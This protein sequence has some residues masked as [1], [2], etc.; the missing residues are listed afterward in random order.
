M[1][2]VRQREA[3]DASSRLACPESGGSSE[4][5]DASDARRVRLC[6]I[7]LAVLAAA[8]LVQIFSPLR[9][10]PDAVIY[11]SMARSAADGEG[12]YPQGRRTHFPPGYPAML[13][14]LDRAGL[15]VSWAFV[16]LN[17]V[18]LAVGLA[19]SYAVLR[20][21]FAFERFSALLLCCLVLLSYQ[22]FKHVA[23]PLSDV[24]FFAVSMLCVLAAVKAEGRADAG[25]WLWAALAGVLV[26]L[27]IPIRTVG[28]AL[29]PAVLWACVGGHGGLLRL[30]GL[31][32]RKRA[33]LLILGALA[34]TAAVGAVAAASRTIYFRELTDKYAE[35]G[36][37]R[38]ALRTV[39]HRLTECGQ[40]ATNMPYTHAPQ[41]L[42]GAFPAIGAVALAVALFGLWRR[43]RSVGVP[44]VYVFSYGLI[45][46]IWPYWDPRFWMPILPLLAA[47]VALAV[48]PVARSRLAGL[49]LIAYLALFALVGVAGLGYTTRISLSGPRFPE[50]YHYEGLEA[51]YRA[52]WGYSEP[53]DPGQINQRALR[54]LRRYEPHASRQ[55][56]T[57]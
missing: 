37:V 26:A 21:A 35:A 17:C 41:L 39:R 16:A 32:G 2:N 20:R 45:L 18:L 54:V 14:A 53:I 48:A 56:A 47:L 5:A 27:A 40:I 57:W 11:L 30:R 9:L 4:T 24:T 15:G 52:A 19:A 31:A 1:D 49:G 6:L 34:L 33:V 7:A 25:R 12:F 38:M 23:L 10:T 29:V 51:T 28:V 42:R 50:F 36:P 22:F 8:Y 3:G 13:A 44:E 55:A 46:L 43:R